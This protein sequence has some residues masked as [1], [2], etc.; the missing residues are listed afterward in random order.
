MFLQLMLDTM[1]A[2]GVF[3]FY[4]GTNIIV[5]IMIF[6]WVPDTKQ[7]TLEELDYIFAVPTRTHMRY[8]LTKALPYTDQSRINAMMQADKKRADRRAENRS[9]S[10]VQ[11]VNNYKDTTSSTIQEKTS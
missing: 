7:R 10:G 8:Q 2:T 6:L 5:L 11:F 9:G 3:G 4:A 1:G